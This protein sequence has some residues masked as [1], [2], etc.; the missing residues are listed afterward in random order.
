MA[1]LTSTSAL[2]K[3][4]AFQTL[5]LLSQAQH[6]GSTSSG[7]CTSN[8][9]QDV[10]VS[11]PDSTPPPPPTAVLESPGQ[12]IGAHAIILSRESREETGVF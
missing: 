9:D 10:V 4:I 2:P 3:G 5:E 6:P 1:S 8:T 7:I 12:E 11:M